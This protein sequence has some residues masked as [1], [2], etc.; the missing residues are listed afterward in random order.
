MGV[1]IKVN[2]DGVFEGRRQLFL[3]GAYK[4]RYPTGSIIV[5][6]IRDKDIVF[7][8]GNY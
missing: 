8:T 1:G 6:A 7:E 3:Q 2:R 4:F 5:V